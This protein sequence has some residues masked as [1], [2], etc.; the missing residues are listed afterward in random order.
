MNSNLLVVH[1]GAPTAVMNASLYG[2]IRSAQK[3]GEVDKV[4]GARGGSQAMLKGDFVDLSALD[5]QTLALLPSTPASYIGTS[6]YPLEETDYEKIIEVLLSQ[7]I[8][9]VLFNGG[10][11]TM[12]A[13]GKLARAIAHTPRSRHIRVIGIPKT[14]DN[15]IAVTDHAPGFGSAA[16]YLA[17]SV[18]ELACDI[19]SLP[20]HV[21]IIE[22]MGRNTGWLT[23]AAALAHPLGPHLIY[24]PEIP[25]D[26]EQFLDEAKTLFDRIGG[27]VV[28]ASEGLKKKD[29]SLLVPPVFKTG[30]SV[31]Y[32]DVSS[33]LSSIVIKRLGIKARNEKPGILGRCSI[34]HQSALDREEA[35]LAGSEAVKAALSGCTA[36]MVG[37]KRLSSIPYR[38]ETVYIPIEDV[39]LH[40]RT[41][42]EEYVNTERNGI[43]RSFLEWCRPLIG[44]P[45]ALFAQPAALSSAHTLIMKPIAEGKRNGSST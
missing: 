29:G 45:L 18:A 43:R 41:L 35:I 19:A 13:C 42:P 26:E 6:R 7:R 16:R 22:S 12:D 10:N 15:D 5:E 2:V 37:F 24:V 3:S 17:A 21:C 36:V 4:L 20:I 28:V 40:E 31:Y 34:A 11:G 39:M 9:C 33:Y 1:G 8:D 44:G 27:V 25:F 23:A 38:A 14:V 30:R 32:G